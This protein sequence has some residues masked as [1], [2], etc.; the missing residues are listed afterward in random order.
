MPKRGEE[1]LVPADFA[2]YEWTK[3]GS[4]HY[5]WRNAVFGKLKKKNG[6]KAF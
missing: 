4:R 6:R 1:L 5:D 2:A 3:S